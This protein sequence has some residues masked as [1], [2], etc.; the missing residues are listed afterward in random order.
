MIVTGLIG[1][2]V[3]RHAAGG[4]RL[5]R[6]IMPEPGHTNLAGLALLFFAL[7]AFSSG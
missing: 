1:I 6:S 7:R 2:V 5:L 3:R 4:E